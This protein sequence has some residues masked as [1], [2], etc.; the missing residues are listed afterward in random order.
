[1]SSTIVMA[2][3]STAFA[4]SL[5]RDS[6]AN[7]DSVHGTRCETVDTQSGPMVLAGGSCVAQRN[8]DQQKWGR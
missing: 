5:A 7:Q 4:A 1:M 2:V 3:I 8:N 6:D